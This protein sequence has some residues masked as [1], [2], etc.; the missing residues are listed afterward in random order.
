[1]LPAIHQA[2]LCWLWFCVWTSA[3]A[4][5]LLEETLLCFHDVLLQEEGNRFTGITKENIF[6]LKENSI[7]ILGLSTD[8]F[9]SSKTA[10]STFFNNSVLI[11]SE[12]KL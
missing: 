1:M 9:K 2:V 5:N 6:Y 7:T 11:V 3:R 10:R 8:D 4:F 12:N